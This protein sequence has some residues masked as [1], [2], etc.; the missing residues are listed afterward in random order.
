MDI[1]IIRGT[2]TD[3]KRVNPGDRVTV[4][5]DEGSLLIKMGRAIEAAPKPKA[6]AKAK[7]K[8]KAEADV[9]G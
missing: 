7:A 6:R 4:S 3:G 1:E 8:P 5:E 2:V 9:A